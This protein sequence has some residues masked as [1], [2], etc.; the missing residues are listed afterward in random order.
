M[1][2]RHNTSAMMEYKSFLAQYMPEA[3]VIKLCQPVRPTPIV[4]RTLIADYPIKDVTK[5]VAIACL[6]MHYANFKSFAMCVANEGAAIV[7]VLLA[8]G[9][10]PIEIVGLFA[11]KEPFDPVSLIEGGQRVPDLL[12]IRKKGADHKGYR[13]RDALDALLCEKVGFKDPKNYLTLGQLAQ[14]GTRM[15]LYITAYDMN[16]VGIV[17][18]SSVT[19]PN[20]AVADAVLASCA[21]QPYIGQVMSDM[22][23]GTTHKLV[24]CSMQQSLP[25]ITAK[26][27]FAS[28]HMKGNLAALATGYG[29]NGTT[30]EAGQGASGSTLVQAL[31]S[32][33]APAMIERD[34]ASNV[35]LF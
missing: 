21:V 33:R 12:H 11:G 19:N 1:A 9:Y 29:Y 17:T 24:S 28:T 5:F 14:M 32:T 30:N 26:Q 10:S 7:A 2:T 6:R 15:P 4:G 8:A 13:F 31:L 27:I 25:I 23:D 3:E 16:S 34:M 35:M 22:L 18:L 20:M